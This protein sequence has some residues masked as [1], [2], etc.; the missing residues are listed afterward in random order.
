M[1][2]YLTALTLLLSTMPVFAK[3]QD[4]ITRDPASF[5]KCH[6]AAQDLV[7][8]IV[9]TASG[10]QD[11]ILIHHP[12]KFIAVLGSSEMENHV[13]LDFWPN[14]SLKRTQVY[15]VGVANRTKKI[16][17]FYSVV[18]KENC[19]VLNSDH[20]LSLLASVPFD[21]AE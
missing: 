9:K 1:K 7:E 16:L 21:A 18:M 11:D 12:L 4:S 13:A 10:T 2:Q 20:P 6:K 15:T 8:K 19:K 3:K 17:N 5:P 14:S